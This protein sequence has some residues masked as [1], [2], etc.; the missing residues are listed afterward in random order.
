MDESGEGDKEGNHDDNDVKVGDYVL[1]RYDVGRKVQAFVAVVRNIIGN[2]VNVAFLYRS[3]E[4]PCVKF[5]WPAIPDNDEVLVS[6]CSKL[7]YPAVDNRGHTTFRKPLNT[8][9]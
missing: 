2:Q 4:N 6:Q 1:V 5:H 8:H 3:T 9:K 7:A